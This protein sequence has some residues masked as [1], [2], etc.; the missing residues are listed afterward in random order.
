MSAAGPFRILLTVHAFPP[1]ATAGVEVYTLRLARA[2]GEQGHDVR[3]LSAVHDLSGEPG[4]IRR[5]SHQGVLVEEVVSIHPRG[6][7]EGTYADPDLEHAASLVL[8]EFRPHIVHIQHLLNLAANIPAQARGLGAKVLLTLHDYWLSCPRDGLRMKADLSL[9]ERMDHAACGRCLQSSP[10][11][12]PALQSRLSRWARR[13]GAGAGLQRLHAA[14]PQITEAVMKLLRRANPPDAQ[15]LA[16]AMDLRAE[17]LRDALSCVDLALAPTRF[18]AERA[19]EFGLP[20]AR[21]RVCAYGA[22]PGPT[23]PRPAGPKR[24]VGFIG[25]VAP[26]KGVHVLV[27][28]FQAIAHPGASLDIHG[29]LSADPAYARR[30]RDAASSDPRIRW[31]GAFPEG[32]QAQVHE[33]LDVLVVPSLWWENSPITALEALADGLAVVASRT[34]GVPEILEQGRSGLLVPP[35]D[36]TALRVALEDVMAGRKLSEALPPLPLKTVTEGARELEALYAS[37]VAGG[38][39]S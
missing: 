39:A 11:L 10:Y 21:L 30:V 28:A 25:T 14:A 34:G 12:V 38:P 19:I 7:L 36:A 9:C 8:R 2:L 4:S 18:C 24:R 13:A 31:H 15:D 23:R 17:R 5:R 3:V 1:R 16:G 20:R 37:L 33:T 32:G 27:D 6:T 26:H 35:G 22:V 29:S